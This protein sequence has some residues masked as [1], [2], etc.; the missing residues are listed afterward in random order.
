MKPTII[1]LIPIN[2]GLACAHCRSPLQVFVTYD[3]AP[4]WAIMCLTCEV[5]GPRH[6]SDGGA[7]EAAKA[8]QAKRDAEQA[9]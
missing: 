8:E 1:A 6:E 9:P 5:V 3:D 2:L 4:H 7:L